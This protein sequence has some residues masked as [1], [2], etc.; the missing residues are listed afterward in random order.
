MWRST[1]TC[2]LGKRLSTIPTPTQL[3]LQKQPKTCLNWQLP[4]MQRTTCLSW[5]WENLPVFLSISLGPGFPEGPL[6][7]EDAPG[8]ENVGRQF[9][10]VS[11]GLS[12]TLSWA[13][14]HVRCGDLLPYLPVHHCNLQEKWNVPRALQK[15]WRLRA[16]FTKLICSHLTSYYSV[17]WAEL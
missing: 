11:R 10:W 15:D 16:L 7:P 8:P 2:D 5:G 13:F 3:K 1:V 12:W 9:L 4:D 6:L 14:C 17:N